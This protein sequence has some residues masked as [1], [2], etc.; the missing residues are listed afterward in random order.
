MRSLKLSTRLRADRLTQN[1]VVQAGV[2]CS[3]LKETMGSHQRPESDL[4]PVPPPASASLDLSL[5]DLIDRIPM[6]AYAVRAPDGVISWYNARA[7]ELWGRRPAIGDPDERFCGSY[8]LYHPDGTFMAHCDTPVAQALATGAS[9]HRQDVVIERPE[10]SRVTVCVHVDP[11]RDDDGRIVG[12]TNFFY[13]VTER[14]LRESDTKLQAVMLQLALQEQATFRAALRDSEERLSRLLALMPAAVY[15]CNAEG[16]ITFFNRRAVEL[17]GREPR[18]NNDEEKF[19]GAF[20]MW[21]SGGLLLKHDQCPMAAAV[22]EDRV[23]RNLEVVLEQPT[24]FR[25]LTNVNIDPLYDQDG[26]L[27]GAI[28]V[29]VDIPERKQAEPV[30]DQNPDGASRENAPLPAV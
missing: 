5:Q 18:L 8:R 30:L 26:R 21:S 4:E 27:A 3:N 23:A 17:W 29:F 25:I 9:L 11:V 24:G 13:D 28:N 22:L 15:T 10:G 7:A 16:R 19:C 6:A 14:K 2:S 20:R 1:G 12:V